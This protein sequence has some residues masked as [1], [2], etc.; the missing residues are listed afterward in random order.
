MRKL[1]QPLAVRCQQPGPIAQML[2]EQFGLQIGSGGCCVQKRQHQPLLPD[3]GGAHELGLI[4]V[5][6][7]REPVQLAPD[8]VAA[9][10]QKF[11]Q[12]GRNLL[13]AVGLEVHLQAFPLVEQQLNRLRIQ[14]LAFLRQRTAA[15]GVQARDQRQQQWAFREFRQPLVALDCAFEQVI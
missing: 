6:L 10:V 11:S 2:F 1:I 12:A 15:F 4:A 14:L 7:E 9:G 5:Y 8:V 3:V 13:R